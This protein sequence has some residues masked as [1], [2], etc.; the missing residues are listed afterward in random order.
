[1]L[2]GSFMAFASWGLSP[3][4]A[5]AGPGGP[6]APG[7]DLFETLPSDFGYFTFTPIPADFFNPGS[8]PFGDIIGLQGDPRSV[9]PRRTPW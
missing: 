3:L 5:L 9:A 2:Y 4:T 6:I 8:D 1:M 7:V